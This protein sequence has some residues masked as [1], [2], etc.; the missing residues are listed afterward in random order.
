MEKSFMKT[1]IS[2]WRSINFS[3]SSSCSSL[4]SK[5]NF[6]VLCKLCA[7]DSKDFRHAPFTSES[8]NCFTAKKISHAGEECFALSLGWS[9]EVFATN[10]IFT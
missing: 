6:S 9:V 3:S 5:K 7:V 10:L 1:N 2:T 8:F 4:S